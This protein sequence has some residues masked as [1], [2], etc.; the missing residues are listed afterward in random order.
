MSRRFI[1]RISSEIAEARETLET[2]GNLA[3]DD[4][5]LYRLH[6]DHRNIVQ[7]SPPAPIVA[8]HAEAALD[9][10]FKHMIIDPAT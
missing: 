5:W 10:V 8:E 6:H 3:F 2:S 1:V 9:L 7:L 4:Q